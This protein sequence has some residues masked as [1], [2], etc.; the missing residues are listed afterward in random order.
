MMY[1]GHAD[2]GCSRSV[3]NTVGLAWPQEQIL[4][5]GVDDTV[6]EDYPAFEFPSFVLARSIQPRFDV[7]R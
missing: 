6:G 3:R 1:G 2:K 4:A 7:P 5:S